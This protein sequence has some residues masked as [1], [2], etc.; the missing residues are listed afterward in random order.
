[1]LV[2]CLT[3]L[4]VQ[5]GEQKIINKKNIMMIMIIKHYLW[6]NW[7]HTHTHNFVKS[8]NLAP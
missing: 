6:I 7:K 3:L 5:S 1:M 2:K 8:L 4:D